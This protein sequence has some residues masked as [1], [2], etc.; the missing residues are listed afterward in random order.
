MWHWSINGYSNLANGMTFEGVEAEIDRLINSH[1]GYANDNIPATIKD[2]VKSKDNSYSVTV[3]N[4]WNP[5]FTNVKSE[6]GS[7]PCLL[8]FAAGSPYSD[9]EGHMTVCV[10]TRE[11]N[12]V[13]YCKVM[14]G[15]STSI[16]EKKW[17]SYNDFMSKVKLSK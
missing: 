16:S 5:S 10:G 17:G 6:V 15:W 11:V 1:G 7:R 12:G 3:T 4:K 2:Y 9:K 14:D 8:G 13:Q